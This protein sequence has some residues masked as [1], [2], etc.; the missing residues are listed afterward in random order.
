MSP[1]IGIV[2]EG[3]GVVAVCEPAECYG[4]ESAAKARARTKT[5]ETAKNLI[6]II[7]HNGRRASAT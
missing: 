7:T 2:Q 5:R 6:V 1:I 4:E 3:V